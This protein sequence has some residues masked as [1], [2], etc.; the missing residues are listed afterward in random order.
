MLRRAAALLGMAL[1]FTDALAYAQTCPMPTAPPS[2][3][4]SGRDRRRLRAM[5][6]DARLIDA[7]LQGLTAL[8][9]STPPDSPDRIQLLRRLAEDSA[10]A[11]S[12]HLQAKARLDELFFDEASS[13]DPSKWPLAKQ[14][15][16]KVVSFPPPANTVY[17]YAWFKLAHALWRS[18]EPAVAAS[19]FQKASE[20]ATAFPQD[21]SAPTL[22]A[23]AKTD[24]SALE[25]A[26]PPLA[27]AP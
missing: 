12:A 9:Q 16:M 15:Y 19:S 8:L 17:G 14:A 7:E 25:R 3:T 22:M 18:G 4:V 20:W 24:H 6:R 11:E 5:P 10:E 23:A 13:G 1:L 21:P 27:A 2:N 26:C